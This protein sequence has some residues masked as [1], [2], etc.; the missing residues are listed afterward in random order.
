MPIHMLTLALTTPFISAGEPITLYDLT[1][2]LKFDAN[3]PHQVAA[4]WDHAHAVAA[5]QGIVNRDAPRLYLRFVESHGMNIDDHWLQIVTQ[6][7]DWL[8]GRQRTTARDLPALIHRYRDEI[9]GVVVYDPNVAATSNLASTIAG[10]ED[11]LPLRYDPHSRSLYTQLVVNGPK[12]PVKVSLLNE[13]NSPLFAGKGTIPGTDRP[14]TGSAKCDAYL[15]LKHHY[16][17]TGKVDAAYAGYYIDQYWLRKPT[18]ANPN[19]HTLTNHDY[20]IARRGFFFDLGVWDDEKPID[21]PDQPMGADV[22][23]LKALML[24]AYQQA[25]RSRMIH[26]G[27][28]T[29][30]AWKYTEHRGAGGTHHP[31]H[32]EW[33]TVEIVSAYNGF[34]DADAIGF[35]ALA[36]ASFFMHYPLK[37]RY[38]QKWVTRDDLIKRG[39]LTTEGQVNFDGREFMIFY[40]GDY[41]SAAWIYQELPRIWRDEARGKIPLM[42]CITPIADRRVP[43]ALDYVRTTATPNDY[44][45]AAD[46]GAGYCTP[47][48]LQE[49]RPHS[50]LPSGL[51]VWAGHC[52]PFYER[53]GLTITGFVIDIS[54]PGLNQKGLDCYARFSPNGI[55]PQNI[56]PSLLHNN[57]PI[58]KAD[59]DLTHD[60]AE[61]ARRILERIEKRHLPFHWFRNIL[62]PPSWYAACMNHV[63]RAN[64]N[65][66][67]LDAPTFFELLRIYLQTNPDAAQ[68]KIPYE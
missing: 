13:D 19:H 16:I 52:T 39:Y 63:H 60:P 14:S 11:L 49:P 2:A 25:G 36:N 42:W 23:T 22:A 50:G 56:S 31:V 1:Y 43:M 28:F 32:T 55:I 41:D 45:A 6:N 8:C 34:I 62:K 38:P 21:D 18:A 7:S 26:V 64:P 47:G 3:N 57:M 9:K 37:D 48:L 58:L 17:D 24:S 51:E 5:L 29:P 4:A 59:Y 35:G 12:L 44:F 46:N 30:W 40:V 67:L 53:W 68:G 66:E 54:A 33:K 61:S 27:G 65:I 20:F 10:V 15:W